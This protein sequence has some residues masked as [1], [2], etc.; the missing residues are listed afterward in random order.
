M[1]NVM[2]F[3]NE[4]RGDIDANANVNVIP[5][6]YFIGDG[7]DVTNIPHG[8]IWCTFIQF[9]WSYYCTQVLLNSSSIK[10][11]KFSGNPQTWSE[12]R[13]I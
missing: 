5:G 13:T 8:S 2:I 11:R 9:P 4:F 3:R 7:S 1:G 12:W 6:I 10:I